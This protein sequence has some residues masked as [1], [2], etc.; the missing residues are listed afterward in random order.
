MAS[1]GLSVVKLRRGRRAGSWRVAGLDNPTTA[2]STPPHPFRVDGPAAGTARMQTSAD[3]EGRTVLGT[4]NNCSGGVT[5]W[6]TV[7]TGEEN[8]DQYFEASS[9]TLPAEYAESYE[10]YGFQAEPERGWGSV[11]P[12]FDLT[13]EPHEAF[14]FGWIVE[15]DPYD[16]KSTPRKH[17][18]LGRFKH[19]GANVV[20][21]PL[22]PRRGLHGRRREGRV[23]LQ[24]RLRRH[25][26]APAARRGRS[27][28]TCSC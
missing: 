2:A 26:C 22:R 17:T 24:V 19:E 15:V 14:R 4:L 3:P 27:A 25:R 9:G 8:I 23:P 6:G 20:D 11:D 12:R 1:H 5:P 13:K 18:M 7:L 16:K 21:L 10:R 28:A